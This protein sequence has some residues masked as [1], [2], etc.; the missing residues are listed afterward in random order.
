[1]LNFVDACFTTTPLISKFPKISMYKALF[2][3]ALT[4]TNKLIRKK[5]GKILA[6]GQIHRV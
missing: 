4:K 6:G 3:Q 5:I 1:M 2:L